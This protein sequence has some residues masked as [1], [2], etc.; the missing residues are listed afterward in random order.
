MIIFLNEFAILQNTRKLSK[1]K[2]IK[3]IDPLIYGNKYKNMEI[4]FNSKYIYTQEI[5]KSLMILTSNKQILAISSPYG[6]GETYTFKTLIPD[7]KKILFN[8]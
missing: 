6:A 7:V 2:F 8:T 4:K 5:E 3:E 1:K